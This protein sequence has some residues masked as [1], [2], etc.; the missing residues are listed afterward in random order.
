MTRAADQANPDEPRRTSRCTTLI[1]AFLISELRAAFI[2]GFVIFVPFLVIDLVVS[3]S[4]MSMGMMMLPAGDDLAAVQAAAVRARR[5]LGADRH[6]P[7]RLLHRRRLT[8]DTNAVLDI[9]M[10]AL[11]LAAKLAAPVLV[12]ALVVGFVVSL[13]PVGDPDPGGHALLRAEGRRR[14]RSRCSS[15]GTG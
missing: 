4:L 7:R 13:L 2:I 3:A 8:M 9:G 6:L 10:Q 1:P 14:R 15:P 12:T 5:R 11:I